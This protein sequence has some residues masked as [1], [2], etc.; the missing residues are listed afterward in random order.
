MFYGDSCKRFGVANEIGVVLYHDRD[1]LLI[2]YL[3]P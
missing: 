1:N 2:R 3:R